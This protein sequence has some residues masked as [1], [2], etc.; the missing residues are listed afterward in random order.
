M[1]VLGRLVL[2]GDFASEITQSPST[3]TKWTK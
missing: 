1:G 2:V 3:A